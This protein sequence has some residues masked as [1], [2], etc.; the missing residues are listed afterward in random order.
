MCLCAAKPS[1][2]SGSQAHTDIEITAPR[3]RY[4]HCAGKYALAGCGS[5]LG[6]VPVAAGAGEIWRVS[7]APGSHKASAHTHIPLLLVSTTLPHHPGRSS[8]RWRCGVS[9]ARRRPSGWPVAM[10]LGLARGQANL[11]T[12]A[13]QEERSVLNLLTC[14]RQAELVARGCQ[15]TM[16][17]IAASATG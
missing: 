1:R 4:F 8:W 16:A 7:T 3:F 2:L 6:S 15:G 12:Y 14:A 11:L 9:R 5:W 13:L 10:G 17:G